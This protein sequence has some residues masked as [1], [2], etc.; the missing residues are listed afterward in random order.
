[1]DLQL[2]REKRMFQLNELDEIHL[3]SYENAILYK[4]KTKRWHGKQ[5][6]PRVFEEG[7]RV[8][9]FNSRLK[10]FPG[11]LKSRCFGPF[12]I[13]KVYPY[14]AVEF[15]GN[16]GGEFKVNGQ[17]LKHYW[18]GFG[19]VLGYIYDWCP[20]DLN[21]GKSGSDAMAMLSGS[22]VML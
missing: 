20:A 8:L 18:G 13:T 17:R 19:S 14:G 4:E 10:L 21:Y 1:M 3:L 16:E 2:A 7:Q 6:Q 11:K 9:I 15:R 5:I 12:T 22:F